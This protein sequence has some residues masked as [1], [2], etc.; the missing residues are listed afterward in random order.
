M[1]GRNQILTYEVLA[2]KVYFVMLHLIL[3]GLLQEIV[4]HDGCFGS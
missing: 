4:Q 3:L 2:L 1:D